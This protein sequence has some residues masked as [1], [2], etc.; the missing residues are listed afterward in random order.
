MVDVWTPI[1]ARLLRMSG[2]GSHSTT[3]SLFL[4]GAGEI[5]NLIEHNSHPTTNTVSS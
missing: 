3:H 5:A 4:P 1:Y 2:A